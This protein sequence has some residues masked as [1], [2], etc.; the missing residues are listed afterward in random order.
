[1]EVSN[2]SAN[3][4]WLNLSKCLSMLLESYNFD[5]FIHKKFSR[6]CMFLVD[7]FVICVE[8]SETN[9][10]LIFKMIYTTSWFSLCPFSIHGFCLPFSFSSEIETIWPLWNICVTNNHEYVSFVVSTSRSFSQ[11][12]IIIEFVTRITRRVPLVNHELLTPLEHLS[13]PPGFSAVRVNRSLVLCVCFV[14]RCLS[15]FFSP[16]CC[17]SFEP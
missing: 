6:I 9:S 2:S 17:L 13:S 4:I 16:L 1:M 10:Y 12:W 5:F 15:F 8:V 11:S 7:N 14:D 3:I